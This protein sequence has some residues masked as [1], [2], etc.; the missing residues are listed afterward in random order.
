MKVKEILKFVF[1]SFLIVPFNTTISQPLQF[2]S[3]IDLNYFNRIQISFFVDSIIKENGF[4]IILVE[5]RD[6]EFDFDF[7]NTITFCGLEIGYRI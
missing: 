4:H 3:E 2:S 7:R 6:K 5:P 1:L